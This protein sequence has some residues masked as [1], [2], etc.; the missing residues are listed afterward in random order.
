MVCE[1]YLKII[2]KNR[3]GKKKKKRK[4]PEEWNKWKVLK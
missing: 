3:E 4:G 2:F 1:L